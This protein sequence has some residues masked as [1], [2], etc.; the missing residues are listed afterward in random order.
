MLVIHCLVYTYAKIQSPLKIALYRFLNRP[1]RV[2]SVNLFLKGKNNSLPVK[3]LF[4]KRIT[5]KL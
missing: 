3:S 4:P 5:N 1:E 2:F